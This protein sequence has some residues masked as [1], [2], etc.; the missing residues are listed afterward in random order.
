VWRVHNF[1][2]NPGRL[3]IQKRALALVGL[4]VLLSIERSL[5]Q[6]YP[7]APQFFPPQTPTAQGL[8][9]LARSLATEAQQTADNV[10]YE[11]SGTYTG[12]Q[13]EMRANALAQATAAFQ[14][15]ANFGRGPE[16]L[17]SF[18][19]VDRAYASLADVLG[20]SAGMAPRT[21]NVMERVQRLSFQIRNVIGS[22]IPGAPG[23]PP[24]CGPNFNARGL[25]DATSNLQIAAERASQVLAS[26]PATVLREAQVSAQNLADQ[27]RFF[28]GMQSSTVRQEELWQMCQQLR[29]VSWDM[30]A[31]PSRVP[32]DP[33]MRGAIVMAKQQLDQICRFLAIDPNSPISDPGSPPNSGKIV[34]AAPPDPSLTPQPGFPVQLPQPPIGA[35]PPTGYRPS[36]E[37]LALLNTA[38]NQSDVFLRTIESHVNQMVQGYQFQ[39]EARQFR[40]NLLVLNQRVREGA[41]RREI[42]AALN[43]ALRSS[44]VISTRIGAL[45]GGRGGPVIN[46]FRAAEQ[47][48]GQLSQ[49][50]R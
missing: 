35:F 40:S 39:A 28:Q 10:R 33:A 8:P 41:P 43:G 29:L 16:L 11:L 36:A 19:A 27:N 24:N 45:V 38:L 15:A 17:Q 21:T 4:F 26:N 20:N 22:Y 18:T 31:L 37:F 42:E 49:V 6:Q 50:L 48:V 13:A 3:M 34:R 14:Q 44:R 1:N 47:M 32:V 5:G 46:Q 30:C 25:A 2:A 12:G 7:A 9:Q 23:L